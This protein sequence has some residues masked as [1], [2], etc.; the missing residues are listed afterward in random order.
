[1]RAPFMLKKSMKSIKI[2]WFLLIKLDE[3][4]KIYLKTK[5]W[6]KSY[7][8]NIFLLH[9]FPYTLFNLKCKLHNLKMFLFLHK[10][11]FALN[12]NGIRW[13]DRDRRWW[14]KFWNG[15]MTHSTI[16]S[17]FKRHSLFCLPSQMN[18]QAISHWNSVHLQQEAAAWPD[19][20]LFHSFFPFR[21]RKGK[22]ASFQAKRSFN[23][24]HSVR[25]VCIQFLTYSVKCECKRQKS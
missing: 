12:E 4:K 13:R 2:V 23:S 22:I 25:Y 7:S 16:L 8:T 21:M 20:R 9:F 18:I 24:I 5:F 19:P 17:K 14:R 1:M 10:S 6:L 11:P 15:K 3:R